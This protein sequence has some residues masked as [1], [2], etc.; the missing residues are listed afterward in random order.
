MRATTYPSR[1]GLEPYK[2]DS[3]K[4]E[5]RVKVS[6][7]ILKPKLAML[8]KK[9]SGNTSGWCADTSKQGPT[10]ADFVMALVLKVSTFRSCLCEAS[11]TVLC[12]KRK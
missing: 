9:I 5:R 7:E 10:I 4:I 1:F 8:S 3:E 11:Y 12:R 2:D 6:E